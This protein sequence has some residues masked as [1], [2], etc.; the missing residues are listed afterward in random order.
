MIIYACV[1]Y[2]VYVSYYITLILQGYEIFG[3]LVIGAKI[4]LS[5]FYV[6]EVAL[7]G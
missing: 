7:P 4:F 6:K 2:L 1:F 5:Q 3:V